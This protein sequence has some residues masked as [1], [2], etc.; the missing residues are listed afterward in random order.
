MT[1]KRGPWALH[2]RITRFE[3]PWL[4]LDDFAVTRP[5]GKPGEYGVVHFKNTAIAILPVFDD[6]TTVLVGQH[7]FPH[8]RYSWEVPE[9]GGRLEEDPLE[10][11]R[12]ELAEETGLRARHWQDMLRIDLSNS[13][14]DESAI[15]FIATGLSQG[16]PDPE[17]TEELRIRRLHFC[18]AVDE[19]VSGK[20]SDALSVAILLKAHYMA[21][22]GLLDQA[23]CAA[24]LNRGKSGD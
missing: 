5:D 12:R 20:I 7:R 14:S 6:G 9:G 23:L 1:Q 4:R 3:N 19:A 16:E 21:S 13:V 10:E 11:A 18:D 2:S 22:N 17:G 15:G 24:M 8:D